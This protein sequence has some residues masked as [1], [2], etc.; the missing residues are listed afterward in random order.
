[1]THEPKTNGLMEFLTRNAWALGLVASSLVAQWAILGYRI[2][3][4]EQ[5]V[6]VLE[7]R[8]G[9]VEEATNRNDV[10]LASIQKDIE[11][12]RLKLDRIIP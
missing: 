8:I 7:N 1:M 10:A 9:V 11:Y 12:I 3:A 2:E 4:N 5:R 6:G